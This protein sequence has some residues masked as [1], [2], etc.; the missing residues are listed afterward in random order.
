MINDAQAFY[1]K[2][3]KALIYKLVKKHHTEPYLH[4][5][6]KMRRRALLSAINV[7]SPAVE[8]SLSA[9]M[10]APGKAI[11]VQDVSRRMVFDVKQ[12]EL[13]LFG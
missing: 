8:S 4:V 13:I 9:A 7:T 11:V 12:T 3:L 10:L 2:M 1:F 5:N 6:N